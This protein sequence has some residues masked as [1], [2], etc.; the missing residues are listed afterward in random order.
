MPKRTPIP[1]PLTVFSA[2]P[3]AAPACEMAWGALSL[4][5]GLTGASEVVL[6]AT[7]GERSVTLIARREAVQAWVAQ[8]ERLVQ[9]RLR[10]EAGDGLELRAPYLMIDEMPAL[11]V[12]RVVSPGGSTYE[13][14]LAGA[15]DGVPLCGRSDEGALRELLAQLR[16][17]MAL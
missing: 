12:A 7:D 1:P 15:R 4:R 5:L 10:V 6:A 11:T 2:P 8:A 16:R 14:R 17:S 3:A 9:P 13:L